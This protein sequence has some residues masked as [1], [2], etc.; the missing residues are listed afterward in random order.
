MSLGE[1]KSSTEPLIADNMTCLH[2]SKPGFHN[3]HQS[4]TAQ[5]AKT[6]QRR[7]TDKVS[8]ELQDYRE[9]LCNSITHCDIVEISAI[10][11][12]YLQAS[13]KQ[14]QEK[15]WKRCDRR[16]QTDSAPSLYLS[17]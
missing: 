15:Q 14:L 12:H 6:L 4:T 1:K 9:L 10:K 8:A 3:T 5:E 7:L 11:E 16:E 17:T 2:G 13:G